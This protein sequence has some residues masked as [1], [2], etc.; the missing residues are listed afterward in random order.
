[1]PNWRF[2]IDIA[3]LHTSSREGDISPRELARGVAARVRNSAAY[4]IYFGDLEDIAAELDYVETLNEY[5][6]S[7]RRLY[8]FA[9]IDHRIWVNTLRSLS[10]QYKT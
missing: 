3:D 2:T 8:D 4:V 6:E 1:M 9:D 7:L 5:N 10:P